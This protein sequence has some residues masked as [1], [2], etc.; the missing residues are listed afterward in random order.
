ME[1]EKEYL[2]WVKD[3]GEQKAIVSHQFAQNM[4]NESF[5][6]NMFDGTTLFE[7]NTITGT[8]EVI[9]ADE[10]FFYLTGLNVDSMDQKSYDLSFL[11]SSGLLL[12]NEMI[13]KTMI[14]GEMESGYFYNE[15]K[16]GTKLFLEARLK[17][18]A[19]REQDNLFYL[20]LID[21]T[22]YNNR[23]KK[24]K[25]EISKL[26]DLLKKQKLELSENEGDRDRTG[27]CLL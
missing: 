3:E 14:S 5:V 16:D 21:L 7:W 11:E 4:V 26:E 23:E 20:A 19:T 22:S 8:I 1:H 18:V 9:K 17:I 15:L 6:S 13:E 24:L 2:D 25:L 27:I 12:L 10:G